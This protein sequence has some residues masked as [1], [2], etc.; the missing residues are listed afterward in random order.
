M[1]VGIEE[2]DRLAKSVIGRA[3]NVNTGVDVDH[4]MFA[5]RLVEEA[6]FSLLADCPNDERSMLGP[7]AAI[8]CDGGGC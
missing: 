3:D 1:A 8:P 4:P 7:G 5:D 6:C 2:I